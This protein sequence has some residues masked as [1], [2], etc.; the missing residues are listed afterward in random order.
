ML[1]IGDKIRFVSD[2]KDEVLTVRHVSPWI[3]SNGD[4]MIETQEY[5]PGYTWASGAVL[6]KSAP[7]PDALAEQLNFLGM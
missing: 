2:T 3:D 1:R 4:F 7:A 6:V 5:A